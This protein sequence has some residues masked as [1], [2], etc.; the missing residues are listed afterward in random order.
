MRGFMYSKIVRKEDYKGFT[1]VVI[2]IGHQFPVEHKSLFLGSD[3]WFCGYVNIPQNHPYYH[4]DY[5]EIYG[6]IDVH[7]GLTF[8]GSLNNIDGY[9]IGFDCNHYDDNHFVQNEDYT[10]KECRKLINQLIK[11]KVD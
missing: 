4:K 1:F 2:K 9:W 3:Y 8:S 7:G 6:E 11:V 10:T 5:Y